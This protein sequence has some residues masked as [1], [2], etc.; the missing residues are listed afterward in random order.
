MFLPLLA[1]VA[2]IL[3]PQGR[4]RGHDS[5]NMPPGLA[6][7][8][9][10][11]PGLAK[12]GGIPPGLAKKFGSRL[13][14]RPWVAID[15]RRTDRAWFLIDGTWQLRTGFNADLRVEIRD[16]LRLPTAL[17]PVPLPRL[18]FDLRVVQFD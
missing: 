8:G 18:G 15:P 12:K 2:L 6:K 13:P 5:G 7:K 14:E 11:P 17:P 9:G 10:V 3:M 16:T 4:G 1:S